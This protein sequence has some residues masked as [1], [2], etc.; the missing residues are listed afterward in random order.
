MI[1]SMMLAGL[2]PEL[3][4]VL[5]ATR[6]LLR[7]AG[8]DDTAEKLE[9][10]YDVECKVL[11]LTIADREAIVRTLDDPPDGLAEL[12]GVLMRARVA[13]ARR[14]CVAPTAAVALATSAQRRA[15]RNDRTPSR[16]KETANGTDRRERRDLEKP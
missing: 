11:E 2:P 5:V 16:E 3:E 4:H 1:A 12:R 13:G 8:F 15:M 9:D 6:R 7:D 14:A 10:A